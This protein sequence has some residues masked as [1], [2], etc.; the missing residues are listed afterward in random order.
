M[1]GP[2]AVACEG[3]RRKAG[4]PRLKLFG[5]S[6]DLLQIAEALESLQ[7]EVRALSAIG[8]QPAGASHSDDC[9]CRDCCLAR[10]AA[11]ATRYMAD[12]IAA[13]VNL[14]DALIANGRRDYE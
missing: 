13:S 14:A 7:R 2:V 9:E 3:L 8:E 4:D 10:I 12:Q 1:T 11:A 5:I 6:D